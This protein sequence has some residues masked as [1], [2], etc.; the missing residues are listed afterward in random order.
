MGTFVFCQLLQIN[1][2]LTL[3]FQFFSSRRFFLLCRFRF[4]LR[5]SGFFKLVSH[6]VT[7][8]MIGLK[9]KL[10]KNAYKGKIAC[11]LRITATSNKIQPTRNIKPPMGVKMPIPETPTLFIAFNEDNKYKDPEK[12]TI[13]NTKKAP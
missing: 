12:S 8:I 3:R 11:Y 13:P 5:F 9:N 6:R 1:L 10:G 7:K 4:N 2:F